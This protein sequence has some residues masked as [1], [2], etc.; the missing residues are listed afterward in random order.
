MTRLIISQ[1]VG[2]LLVDREFDTNQ[3]A[4]D[5]ALYYL[6]RPGI[7]VQIVTESMSPAFVEK[8]KIASAQGL[9]CV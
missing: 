1:V 5:V 3:Q 2:G 4:I 6:A 8:V 7:N 9:T